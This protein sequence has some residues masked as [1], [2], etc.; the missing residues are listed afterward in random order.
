M[1]PA[2]PYRKKGKGA[3]WSKS[4]TE[5]AAETQ[6]REKSK[7]Q[8]PRRHFIFPHTVLYIEYSHH[9]HTHTQLNLPAETQHNCTIAELSFTQIIKNKVCQPCEIW[10]GATKP[11]IKAPRNKLLI[12]MS[13]SQYKSRLNFTRPW[14]TETAYGQRICNCDEWGNPSK[15]ARC[16]S[17]LQ[18]LA[19]C[20]RTRLLFAQGWDTVLSARWMTLWL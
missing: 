9:K 18:C 2:G 1:G 3:Y 13:T 15:C 5:A 6:R 17:S 16:D 20:P 7:P 4:M 11:A 10:P 14:W 19:T 8:A 12:Q